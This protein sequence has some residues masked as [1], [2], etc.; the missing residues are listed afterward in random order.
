[1]R[2]IRVHFFSLI[3]LRQIADINNPFGEFDEGELRPKYVD[4]IKSSY[5]KAE[6]LKNDEIFIKYYGSYPVWASDR[7]CLAC[8]VFPSDTG[9]AEG[10]VEVVEGVEFFVEYKG[11]ITIWCI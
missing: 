3:T 8:S 1:M 6:D 11:A 5:G 7:I 10:T 9:V 2:H 4:A